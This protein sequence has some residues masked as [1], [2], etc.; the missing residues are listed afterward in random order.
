MAGSTL[1]VPAK[2]HRIHVNITVSSPAT[3]LVAANGNRKSV[4]FQ[5]KDAGTVYLGGPAVDV[6]GPNQG[7]ALFTGATFTD[8]ASSEEWWGISSG[9]NLVGVTDVA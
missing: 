5:N 6:S 4:T 7:Y 1:V 8:N 9:S 2:G 3:R